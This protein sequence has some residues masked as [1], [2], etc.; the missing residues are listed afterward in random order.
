M[1]DRSYF[2]VK[3]KRRGAGARG[4]RDSNYIFI[5]SL[6][7]RASAPLRLIFLKLLIHGNYCIY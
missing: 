7:P 1:G 3:I 6:R 4:R 5:L 2:F